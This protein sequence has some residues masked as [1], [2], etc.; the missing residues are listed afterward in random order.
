[1]LVTLIGGCSTRG[2]TVYKVGD[3]P[4][5]QKN[6]AK[7]TPDSRTDREAHIGSGNQTQSRRG[8]TANLFAAQKAL[9]MAFVRR[10]GGW[11]RKELA[12]DHNSSVAAPRVAK[13]APQVNIY[14]RCQT[15][16]I[17]SEDQNRNFGMRQ[18]FI[19]LT[20]NQ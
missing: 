2:S 9:N 20:P 16:K 3:Q 6:E 1:M 11:P 4:L 8:A 14:S 18:H 13:S 7:R 19:D 12:S 15:L 17:S 10:I 5:T